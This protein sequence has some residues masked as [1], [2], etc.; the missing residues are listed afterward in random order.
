[1]KVMIDV[2]VEVTEENRVQLARIIDGEGT[3]KRIATRN[4]LKAFIWRHG[5]DWATAL[6]DQFNEAT[7]DDDLLG[8]PNTEMNTTDEPDPYDDDLLG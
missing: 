8:V 7:E 6:G 1:M 3:K 5:E 2:T 4:E